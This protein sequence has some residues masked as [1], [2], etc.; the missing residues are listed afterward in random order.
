MEGCRLL[1][2]GSVYISYMQ[3]RRLGAG[4]AEAATMSALIIYLRTHATLAL[5]RPHLRCRLPAGACVALL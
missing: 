4:S 3:G 1:P 5:K 2:A